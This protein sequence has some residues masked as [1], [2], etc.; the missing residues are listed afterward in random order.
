MNL[1]QNI[2]DAICRAVEYY[3]SKAAFADAAGIQKSMPAEYQK[4]WMFKQEGQ[5]LDDT[6]ERMYPAL[7]PFLPPGPEYWP[8]STL[9]KKNISLPV[10][11]DPMLPADL[12]KLVRELADIWPEMSEDCK[13][14]LRT[15]VKGQASLHKKNRPLGTAKT[16]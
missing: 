2:Y 6:W 9:A 14:M 13:E 4:R 3:G 1:D 15:M 16:A 5:I 7:K 12:A 8:R 10:R 11:G